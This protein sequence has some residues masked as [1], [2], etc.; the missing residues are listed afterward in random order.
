LW[1]TRIL[2]NQ[3]AADPAAGGNIVDH[4]FGFSYKWNDSQTDAD[5]VAEA[6]QNDNIK[7]CANGIDVPPIIKKWTFPAQK[8]CLACHQT[9]STALLH[10]R[11]ILGFFTA[12]LNRPSSINIGINQIDYLFQKNI[13]TGSKPTNWSTA[14]KWADIGDNSASLS[15]RARSYIAANCSGCHGT[16]GLA[17]GAAKGEFNYD[18]YDMIPKVEFINLKSKPLG[19]E[20]IAPLN[21]TPALVVPGYPEKSMILFRQTL[22]NISPNDYKP[23]KEQMPPLGSFEINTEATELIRKWILGLSNSGTSAKF[24]ALKKSDFRV[25]GR[26]IYLETRSQS[27]YNAPVF[28]L[29]V[30]G[31]STHLRQIDFG[32][33]AI[34]ENY[35][36]GNYLLKVG[37]AG[38]KVS[39]QLRSH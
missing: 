39:F 1:E 17:L 4:W 20:L 23:T 33:Y 38:L 29:D 13:L 7:I 11:A 3:K 35:P 24:A 16:R 32:V 30:N 22:R 8:E 6:G 36:P 14:P 15:V 5:L 28:V 19:Q 10:G 21:I 34:P 31:K 12:Q 27:Q 37:N 26:K 18:Y 9:K 2:I 25:S